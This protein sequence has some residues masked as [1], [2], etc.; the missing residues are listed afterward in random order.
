M[1]DKDSQG[2]HQELFQAEDEVFAALD[3]EL[4]SL[5]A[6]TVHEEGAAAKIAREILTEGNPYHGKDG[7]F[8][9][10]LSA[11]ESIGARRFDPKMAHEIRPGHPGR[12]AGHLMVGEHLLTHA[13][14]G[15][16]KNGDRWVRGFN[17][18]REIVHIGF[19]GKAAERF[20][21]PRTATA[22]EVQEFK[23]AHVRGKQLRMDR[24]AGLLIEPWKESEG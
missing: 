1:L 19:E 12:L 8:A 24:T 18:K 2:F 15:N 13:V 5:D 7:R 21:A 20:Q 11:A 3:R 9:S 22:T 4:G 6:K 10:Q 14:V 23:D 16:T 17:G